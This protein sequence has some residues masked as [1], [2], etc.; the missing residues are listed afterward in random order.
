MN[1]IEG[2]IEGRVEW[3]G[4]GVVV[5]KERSLAQSVWRLCVHVERQLYSATRWVASTCPLPRGKYL[6]RSKW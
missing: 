2:R 4:N 5:I 3:H 1:F 6:R